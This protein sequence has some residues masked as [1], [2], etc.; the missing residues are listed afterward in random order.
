MTPFQIRVLYEDAWRHRELRLEPFQQYKHLFSRGVIDMSFGQGWDGLFLDFL[1]HFSQVQQPDEVI[2]Q[3]KE[4]FADLRI[5]MSSGSDAIDNLI[6]AAEEAASE[7]CEVTGEKGAKAYSKN[8]WMKT[9]H[10][11]T[12]AAIGYD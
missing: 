6:A 12:A 5:Y 10:P 8:G 4:K 9:L 11:T 3:A 1:K 2:I 7:T